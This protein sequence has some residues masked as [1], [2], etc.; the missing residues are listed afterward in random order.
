MDYYTLDGIYDAT[1]TTSRTP[2]VL[3]NS[4][5]WTGSGLVELRFQPIYNS[6][7]LKY[8]KTTIEV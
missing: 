4:V 7:T 8:L 2:P 6:T 5:S 3:I 1:T